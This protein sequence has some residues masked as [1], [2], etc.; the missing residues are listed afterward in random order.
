MRIECHHRATRRIHLVERRQ[1]QS[2]R[3][4]QSR[5]KRLAVEIKLSRR[6]RLV[7]RGM[8]CRTLA[9]RSLIAASLKVVDDELGTLGRRL[10]CRVVGDNAEAREI[11][12]SR[13]QLLVKQRQPVL[14]ADITAAFRDSLIKRVITGRSAEQ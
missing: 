11:I 12:K 7:G 10:A 6:N 9:L 13:F 3:L 5:S 14:H 2:R 8:R 1:A 4:I